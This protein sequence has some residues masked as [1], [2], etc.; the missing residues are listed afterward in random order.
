[1]SNY[2]MVRG[3]VLALLV[4]H[5]QL[6]AWR[7]EVEAVRLAA[8]PDPALVQARPMATAVFQHAGVPLQSQGVAAGARLPRIHRSAAT[9]R[10]CTHAIPGELSEYGA[11]HTCTE[12]L[13][14]SQ[15]LKKNIFRRSLDME[16]K[17]FC[18]SPGKRCFVFGNNVPPQITKISI[19]TH[20]M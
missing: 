16:N 14:Y 11:F 12:V 2:V 15:R 19:E 20:L 6:F 3:T 10:A 18:G 9:G 8:A 13:A 4:P 5:A 1:M 17:Q 7:V